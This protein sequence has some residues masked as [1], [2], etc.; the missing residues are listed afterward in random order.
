MTGQAMNDRESLIRYLSGFISA[1]VNNQDGTGA[2]TRTIADQISINGEEITRYWNAFWTARQRQAARIH[3]ISYRACFKPQLPRFFVS[4]LTVPGDWV[5]DPFGGR[6]TTAIEAALWG[7]IPISNDINPLSS[8]L[9]QP[10]LCI[11]DISCLA[12]R[13]NHVPL[14]DCTSAEQDL[15]MFYHPDTEAWIVSLRS[16]L[17]DR[18]ES[19]EYDMLDAWIRM[20]ATNRLTGHSSGFFSV[21]T[22]PPNQA[23]T[24]LR[25]KKINENRKQVPP[26][27]N[28]KEIILKKSYQLIKGLTPDDISRLR[29][30]GREAVLLEEDARNT[31]AICDGSVQLTVTSPPFLN[32][33]QYSTDN[34]LRCWFNGIDAE[35]VSEGITV[36][37]RISTWSAIM[38]DVFC[39]LYRVTADGGFVAFEVGE[40]SCGTIMLDE[41]VV[42]L[43][44]KAGFSC[45]GIVIN[46]QNFTK[47]ANIWGIS[48]MSGG[49]NTNR[50]VLF[51]K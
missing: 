23:T 32:M 17:L 45:A 19:G 25:Q 40:V 47:T 20:V 35:K 11:P 33:V 51:E 50:I 42:P 46:Q 44:K 43:G 49:T 12:D 22:L 41:V 28:V 6:G 7:R 1:D 27:R 14:M 38:A 10:R 31:S 16:Y 29:T 39:E 26:Y 21:Y 3:E 18:E 8:L 2:A 13:L 15:S 5:Y 30:A 9:I 24:P 48:N 34:W 36:P 4:L 37:N